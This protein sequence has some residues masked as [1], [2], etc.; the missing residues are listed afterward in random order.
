VDFMS[1]LSKPRVRKNEVFGEIAKGHRS[2]RESRPQDSLLSE[3]DLKDF[4]LREGIGGMF[5][6]KYCVGIGGTWSSG[7][8]APQVSVGT[9]RCCRECDL[10]PS[11]R[12]GQH[13][14]VVG[15]LACKLP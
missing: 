10:W 5:D 2:N 13:N 7:K 3:A 15:G 12:A 6:L 4:I 14:L 1:N 11:D 9:P 8:L